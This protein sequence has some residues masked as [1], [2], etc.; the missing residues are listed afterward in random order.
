MTINYFPICSIRNSRIGVP[1]KIPSIFLTR[2]KIPSIICKEKSTLEKKHE[3][4][5]TRACFRIKGK[6]PILSTLKTPNQFCQH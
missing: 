4:S 3:S 2:S 1:R 5:N 6:T